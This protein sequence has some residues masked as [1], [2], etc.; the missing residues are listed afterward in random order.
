MQFSP[1]SILRPLVKSYSVITIEKTLTDEVFYPSGYIYFVVNISGGSAATI[2]N[3]YQKATPEVELLGHLTLPTRVSAAKGTSVLIARL[4]PYACSL[5]FPNPI[6]D[7][8]NYATDLY[9]AFSPEISDFYDQMMNCA[10]LTEKVRVLDDFLLQRLKKNEDRY[11]KTLMVA[12]ICNFLGE[13]GEKIE[14]GH[15]SSKLGFSERYLQKLFHEKVGLS[16]AALF[17]VFRFNKALNLVLASELSLTSVAYDCGYYDQAHFI[18]EF[19]KFTGIKPSEA[20]LSLTKN[21]EKFQQAVNI[22]V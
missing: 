16:P 5:F 9:Q 2:I 11:R 20:R 6:A 1:S 14:T 8:T 18:K 10:L 21:G 19:K 13:D 3:G 17:S 12:Q 22:G 7:F 15:L 4:Y